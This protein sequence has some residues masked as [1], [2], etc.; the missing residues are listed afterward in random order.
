[1]TPSDRLRGRTVADVV[2]TVDLAPTLADL[3]SIPL[4]DRA[5]DDRSP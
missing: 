2:R 5:D 3:L 1:L 4:T